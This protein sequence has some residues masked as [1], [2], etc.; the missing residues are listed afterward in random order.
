MIRCHSFT[1]FQQFTRLFKT[2]L[3]ESCDLKM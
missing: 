1:V 3:L 2:L